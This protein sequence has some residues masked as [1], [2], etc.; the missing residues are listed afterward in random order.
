[1]SN[2]KKW[3][4][5]K[6]E[7]FTL[8][9][10]GTFISVFFKRDYSLEI[11]T[12]LLNTA[13]WSIFGTPKLRFPLKGSPLICIRNKDKLLMLTHSVVAYSFRWICWAFFVCRKARQTFIR[14]KEHSLWLYRGRSRTIASTILAYLDR[15]K[16]E[17][18]MKIQDKK[19]I[20][21][22]SKKYVSLKK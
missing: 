21:I 20:G 16:S 5:G 19:R 10:K 17:K 1:M 13:V 3:E 2:M 8:V 12:R 18:S 15:K 11:G 4:P 22:T 7:M 9:R 14:M 6:P